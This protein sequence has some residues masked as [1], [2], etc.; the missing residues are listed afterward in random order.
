MPKGTLV[1]KAFAVSVILLSIALPCIAQ[2]SAAGEQA[3]EKSDLPAAILTVFEKSY[4][5][6]KIIGCSKETQK[7]TVVYEIESKDGKINRDIIYGENG[8]VISLEESLPFS[9]L[10]KAVQN[11]I[12]KEFPKFRL[13]RCEKSVEGTTTQ[14]ELVLKSGKKSYEVVF[15]GDGKMTQ[16]EEMAT[17]KP[18]IEKKEATE[19]K[20][21]GEEGKEGRE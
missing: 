5:N 12:R 3:I 4:P 21:T 19:E 18:V 20:E 15:D 2:E 7:D 16:K 14:F 8:T 6:A 10:P 9:A 11:G 1:K 17:P 13:I